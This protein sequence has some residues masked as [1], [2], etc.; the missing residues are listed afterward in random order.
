[1]N[2]QYYRKVLDE[3]TRDILIG[4]LSGFIVAMSLNSISVGRAIF[5]MTIAG[6]STIIVREI[7]RRII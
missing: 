1:M 3:A 5:L 4:L 6:V 2:S 7:L